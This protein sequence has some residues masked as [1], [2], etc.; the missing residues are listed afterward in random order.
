[1]CAVCQAN[2]K[3]L[4]NAYTHYSY[5]INPFFPFSFQPQHT[6]NIESNYFSS[7][8]LEES[9]L[10]CVCYWPLKMLL[11]FNCCHISGFVCLV[12]LNHVTIMLSVHLLVLSIISSFLSCSPVTLIN[13]WPVD[14]PWVHLHTNTLTHKKN[15]HTNLFEH[16]LTGSHDANSAIWWFIHRIQMKK[17]NSGF[18]HHRV[19]MWLLVLIWNWVYLKLK[20]TLHWN[21][22]FESLVLSLN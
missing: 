5:N 21:L 17:E 12:L 4:L 8:F 9:W 3:A 7:T 20:C 1:M 13:F 15:I 16:L 14:H 19:K 10:W 6:T 2:C 22:K 11:G 18:L